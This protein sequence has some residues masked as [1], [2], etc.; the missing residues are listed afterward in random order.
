MFSAAGTLNAG[1]T[2]AALSF[3]S[4]IYASAGLPANYASARFVLWLRREGLLPAVEASLSGAGK[5]LSAVLQDLYVS[6]QLAEAILAARPDFAT[7]KADASK[8]IKAQYT[9]VQAIPDETFV[10]ALDEVVRAQGKDGSVPLTLV[11]LDELQQFVGDDNDRSNEVQQ[12][13]EATCAKFGSRVIIAGT[14]QM[15]LSATRVIQKLQDRFTVGVGL[16]DSDVDRVV[17]AVVLRKKPD[18]E[19]EIRQALDRAA[20][21]ISR[22]LSGSA[23]AP[24]VADG[25]DLVADYPF[26]PSRRRFWDRVLRAMDTAGRSAKLRTQLRIMLDATKEVAGREIGVVVGAD[27]IYDQLREEFLGSGA[28][29]RDTAT[30]I[31]NLNND[32]A[33]GSLR[34]RIAKVA[35]LISKLPTE[36]ARPAGV[37]ANSDMITDLL[38]EDLS[39]DGPRLRAAVP[40][41]LGELVKL[42]VLDDVHGQYIV[43]TPVAAEWRADE[44]AHRRDVTAD[45][46][47]IA[48]EREIGIR[49]SLEAALRVIRPTQGET[50]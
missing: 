3:L 20:G 45:E 10:E 15:A 17:R 2:S 44:E 1:G 46:A 25:A 35:F 50:R 24:A 14:G 38:V 9:P 49:A 42:G 11:V 6:D 5:T 22:H 36:G 8:S 43:Q 13:V 30:L 34:C 28:L 21:E 33:D 29:P 23:I 7:S 39:S 31:D 37:I 27:A 19:V 26:L 16:R 32:T 18:R 47:W 12:L 48:S 40:N 41:A 4:I